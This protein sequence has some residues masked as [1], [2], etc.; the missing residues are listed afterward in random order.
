MK[1]I[2]I[3][4]IMCVCQPAPNPEPTTPAEPAQPTIP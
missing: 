3:M 1:Y 2:I 4:T